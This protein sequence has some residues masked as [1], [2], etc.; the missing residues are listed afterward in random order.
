MGHFAHECCSNTQINMMDQQ[1][2][3]MGNCQDP[4]EPEIDQIA[5]IRMEIGML[6]IV[7]EERLIKVLESTKGF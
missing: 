1:E 3:D 6:S 4:L 2:D 5:R 7:G